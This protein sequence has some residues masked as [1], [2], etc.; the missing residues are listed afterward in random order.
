MPSNKTKKG[1]KDFITATQGAIYSAPGAGA[2]G[3]QLDNG[4]TNAVDG[5]P[6]TAI[7]LVT[8]HDASSSPVPTPERPI[9]SL[10][11][12]A[13]STSDHQFRLCVHG[14][15]NTSHQRSNTPILHILQCVSRKTVL[16]ALKSN[17]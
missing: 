15:Y 14:T 6:E 3:P 13:S 7:D 17:E 9:A 10:M 1:N 16:G 5:E 8:L 11:A 12:S 4:A 2:I